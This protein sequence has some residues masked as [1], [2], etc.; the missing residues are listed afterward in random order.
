MSEK[1]KE[2]KFRIAII[3]IAGC[4][5]FYTAGNATNLF[6]NPAFSMFWIISNET[7]HGV[8]TY[9]AIT[10]VVA[11]VIIGLTITLIKKWKTIRPQS[12][13]KPVVSRVKTTY[14][15]SVKAAPP[16]I[17]LKMKGKI[18]ENK[19]EQKKEPIKQP[20]I[21][22]TEQSAAQ[23]LTQPTLNKTN[24]QKIDTNK[25]VN[26]KLTCSN[27]KKQFSTP[28]FMLEYVQSK[29]KLVGHCPYCDQP[30][31]NSQKDA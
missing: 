2:Q 25:P 10:G 12:T 23:R 16:T 30:L 13:Y 20:I 24:N 1:F 14:Q 3:V 19:T 7:A 28:L 9:G 11:V 22:L 15:T 26:G 27:C 17:T 8:A 18:E 29:P 21:Q 6:G 5:I 4:L 31:K